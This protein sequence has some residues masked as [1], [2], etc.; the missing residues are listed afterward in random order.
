MEQQSL[1]HKNYHHVWPEE[2]RKLTVRADL[3]KREWDAIVRAGHK[4]TETRRILC[5]RWD[6][7][8]SLLCRWLRGSRRLDYRR[9]PVPPTD[10][11]VLAASAR[12]AQALL[13]PF[14][15]NADDG[16]PSTSSPPPPPTP[17]VTTLPPAPRGPGR[18]PSWPPKSTRPRRIP[19]P[20][21]Q[22]VVASRIGE[23][24]VGPIGNA[25][26]GD[27]NALLSES[28]EAAII[29]W[30]RFRLDVADLVTVPELVDAANAAISISA[31]GGEAT[32]PSSQSSTSTAGTRT[33]FPPWAQEFMLCRTDLFWSTV[34][35]GHYNLKQRPDP[36]D[37][38]FRNWFFGPHGPEEKTLKPREP[39][40]TVV[41]ADASASTP[42]TGA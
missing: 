8:Y 32:D 4:T 18:P 20:R 27:K 9:M 34:K 3:A 41:D 10:P 5:A 40:D 15:E 39:F 23:A 42:A 22:Y 36:D 16:P 37:H 35:Y 6:I 28:E 38:S 31:S 12:A 7:E 29:L 26:P 24:T 1:R 17:Q 2:L 30:F 21:P 19:R 14:V 11:A 13:P 25:W 33:A